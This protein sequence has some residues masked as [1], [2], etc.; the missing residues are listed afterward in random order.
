MLAHGPDGPVAAGAAGRAPSCW[1]R[2]GR[3]PTASTTGHRSR[4][5][6]RAGGTRAPGRGRNETRKGFVREPGRNPCSKPKVK[7]D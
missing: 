1:L 5:D 3:N 4:G 7:L 2:S 6:W